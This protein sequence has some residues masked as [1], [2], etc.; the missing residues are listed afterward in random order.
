MTILLWILQL[1]IALHTLMGAIWK[2][3]HPAQSLPSLQALPQGAWLGLAV[4]EVLCSIALLVPLFLKA[5]GQLAPFA[6][7][8]IA[9]EML[10]FCGLHLRSGDAQHSQLVYWLIVAAICAFIAYGRWTLKTT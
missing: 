4:A 9:L 3:S 7:L 2:F 8:V 1:L 5:W 6:V 10:L